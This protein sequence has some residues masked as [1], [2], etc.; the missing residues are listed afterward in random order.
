MVLVNLVAIAI[1]SQWQFGREMRQTRVNRVGPNKTATPAVVTDAEFASYAKEM[2]AALEKVA[3]DRGLDLLSHLL[4]MAI[5]EAQFI[6]ARTASRRRP[7]K[8]GNNAGARS[9]SPKAR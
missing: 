6:E 7:A 9:R 3:C 5:D 4:G 2:L 1:V 8:G